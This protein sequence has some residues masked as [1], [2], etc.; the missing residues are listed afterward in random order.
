MKPDLRPMLATLTDQ[1]FDDPGWIFETKWDG[2][3]AIAVAEPGRAWLYSRRGHDLSAKYPT[4]CDALARIKHKAVLDGEL[5]AID[6]HGR[7]RFQ[8]LQ[9]AGRNSVPLLYCVFDLL[10]LDGKDLRD[11]PLLKRKE[12]LEKILPKS[13]LLLYST[14][15]AGDGIKA[16]KHAA[17]G[18]EEGVI[19]KRADSPYLSSKRTRDWLKVKASREQEAVIVGF[20]KPKGSRPFFGA[21]VLA[22]RDGK[23]WK[24]AG[25]VGSGFNAK[26]LQELNKKLVPL[27]TR[28]KPIEARVPDEANTVWVKPKAR[29]SDQVHRMDRGRRDAPSGVPG[30]AHRQT[31]E[32]SGAR[33]AEA[34][35]GGQAQDEGARQ[36]DLI[37]IKE[38]AASPP[39]LSS[40]LATFAFVGM[41][42]GL[43]ALGTRTGF[44][45]R[46]ER[47]FAVVR[48]HLVEA[49]LMRTIHVCATALSAT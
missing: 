42:A 9:N 40:G 30:L 28:A 1:P 43:A 21:L 8:L 38:A 24:Y 49:R 33:D 44:L 17:R 11:W 26:W 39:R 16:F 37:G 41:G 18:G 34:L 6:A 7:S 2:F 13:P 36:K 10:Y 31:G 27:V 22:V 45:Q 29:R 20:T 23:R 14:H 35:A 19:A 3:R 5:V 4:I 15:V 32:P 25:R 48:S 12:A 46:S 47:D